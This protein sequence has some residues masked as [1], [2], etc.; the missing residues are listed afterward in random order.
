MLK[1]W[2][3]VINMHFATITYILYQCFIF[4]LI[5]SVGTTTTTAN[6][7]PTTTPTSTTTTAPNTTTTTTSTTSHTSKSI[8]FYNFFVK[9]FFVQ[10]IS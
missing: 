9:V 5:F 4:P 7:I 10:I 3:K 1:L 6:T 8:Q 2:K